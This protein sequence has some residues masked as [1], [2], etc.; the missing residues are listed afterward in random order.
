LPRVVGNFARLQAL[1]V[2]HNAFTGSLPPAL[3]SIASLQVLNA[4]HN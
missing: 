3:G 4:S 1:D 2:S